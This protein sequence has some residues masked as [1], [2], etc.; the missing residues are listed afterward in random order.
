MA[1]SAVSGGGGSTATAV[2]HRELSTSEMAQML[3]NALVQ[4][5]PVQQAHTLKQLYNTFEQ[6][7]LTV[8]VSLSLLSIQP[9]GR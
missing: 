6:Q 9:P 3:S 8:P 2:P 5:D 1:S 4:H 7:P